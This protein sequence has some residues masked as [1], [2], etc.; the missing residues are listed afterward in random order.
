MVLTI[1]EYCG[2][3][4]SQRGKIK[5]GELQAI[6]DEFL[7]TDEG[8]VTSIRG[9]IREELNTKLEEMKTELSNLVRSEVK[10]VSDEN[11]R[12]AE[13]NKNMKKILL[14]HQKFMER[15]RREETKNNI[16]ISGIPNAVKQDFQAITTIDDE[17]AVTDHAEIIH[18]VVKFVNPTIKKEDYK[19]LV[20]FDAKESHTRHSAKIRVENYNT[21]SNIFKGCAKFKTLEENNYLRRIFLKNDD[22]PLTR[23]ENERLQGKMKQLRDLEDPIDPE[24]K[25]YIKKGTLFKNNEPLDEFNLNN[26]LFC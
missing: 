21:K 3:N 5:R 18:H 6:L 13:E 23:K 8:S 7:Q 22:P 19:I 4:A 14:E 9:I 20:N 25:Y 1:E 17:N 16:F 15:A 10:T 11:K 26:Q 12:L 2:F 24:N